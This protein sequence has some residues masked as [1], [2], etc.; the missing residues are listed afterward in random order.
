MKALYMRAL[1]DQERETLQVG[2][3]SSDG[4]KVRRCQMILLSADEQLKV[5]EIGR[6]LGCQGQAVREAIHAFERA[7]LGCLVARSRA[8]HDKQRA[9]NE[10]GQEGLRELIRRSP[11][12]FGYESSLWTLDLVAQVCAHEGLTDKVVTG[13]TIRTTLAA[14]GIVWKRAK[15]WIN[16]PDVHYQSKKSGETG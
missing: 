14:M 5:A 9:F 2:L 7:G 11:R 10:Q 1:T 3:K 8:R 4:F 13:E 6:R 15:H 16:S 12:E